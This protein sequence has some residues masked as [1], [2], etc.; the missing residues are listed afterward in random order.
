MSTYFSSSNALSPQLSSIKS[1]LSDVLL[2]KNSYES[3]ILFYVNVNGVYCPLNTYKINEGIYEFELSFDSPGGSDTSEVNKFI[4]WKDGSNKIIYGKVNNKY[5]ELFE[6]VEIGDTG[7]IYKYIRNMF[8]IDLNNYEINIPIICSSDLPSINHFHYI[9]ENELLDKDS[10]TYTI[11]KYKNFT[12]NS[13]NLNNSIDSFSLVNNYFPDKTKDNNISL[14]NGNNYKSDL[15]NISMTN[16]YRSKRDIDNFTKAFDYR[17]NSGDANILVPLTRSSEYIDSKEYINNC[18]QE[19][20]S[21]DNSDQFIY[22]YGMELPKNQNLS[23]EN[24]N[25]DKMYILCT[26]LYRYYDITLE[27]VPVNKFRIV[28][29]SDGTY[30]SIIIPLNSN[31]NYNDPIS[32][33]P[34]FMEDN[35]GNDITSDLSF[36]YLHT[37][38]GTP[39]KQIRIDIKSDER[40]NE[41]INNLSSYKVK[42][43]SDNKLN[44]RK[45][46]R[47]Y[48]FGQNFI[49]NEDKLPTIDNR[50][51]RVDP[52]EFTINYMYNNTEY[53]NIQS[54]I[55]TPYDGQVR[56]VN[57]LINDGSITLQR[58][59][60]SKNIWNDIEE[61]RY[62]YKT[63]TRVDLPNGSKIKVRYQTRSE[64]PNI[65]KEAITIQQLVN[66]SWINYESYTDVQ[67][68]NS[69]N[70]GEL[71]YFRHDNNL[72]DLKKLSWEIHDRFNK[73][74]YNSDSDNEI[75]F[76]EGSNRYIID[77]N[78][79]YITIQELVW[80]VIEECV[81]I[82][83]KVENPEL[84]SFMYVKDD[85]DN[86]TIYQWTGAEWEL[87]RYINIPKELDDSGFDLIRYR[88]G[89]VADTITLEQL[90]WTTVEGFE[91][92]H[93][94]SFNGF[95]LNSLRYVRINDDYSGPININILK[96]K[97]IVNNIDA[98][99]DMY[100]SF[101]PIIISK[102]LLD[103]PSESKNI[104]I[105]IYD[106]S[107]DNDITGDLS[108][109]SKWENGNLVLTKSVSTRFFDS[110]IYLKYYNETEDNNYSTFTYEITL[111]T[112]DIDDTM[113]TTKCIT[114]DRD[115]FKLNDYIDSNSRVR[116]D[117]DP[118]VHL[119]DRVGNCL[120]NDLR[121]YTRWNSDR[122]FEI[123]FP[124]M[125]YSKFIGLTLR[126]MNTLKLNTEE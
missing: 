120:D 90:S 58:Y 22:M 27:S 31:G 67:R 89:S 42:Y 60:S 74:I 16:I 76:V 48:S 69:P 100:L 112:D 87:S 70:E 51:L 57:S 82:P 49:D 40:Y 1:N 37:I 116:Y 105:F 122:N 73:V 32:D 41:L 55:I 59:D 53:S 54:T 46:L 96:W 118:V 14:F 43:Y 10:K 6:I 123:H 13:R 104:P 38:I 99:R 9:I 80:E 2:N 65:L 63:E 83:S 94:E 101:N 20:Y 4:T 29:S 111:H 17:S 92:I 12:S 15:C 24:F 86:V 97:D 95:S 102:S 19:V 84:N 71:R 114:I 108:I 23:T 124:A 30:H 72:I 35:N 56:Y 21:F 85:L 121:I 117:I 93:P 119:Y 50:V 110:G 125:N 79:D 26:S 91:D 28:E 77:T 88:E 18:T 47:L 5:V 78:T 107:N 81:D 34:F 3:L 45:Y 7:K 33:S 106:G 44:P 98:S 62:I 109:Q 36:S 66:D 8:Y 115:R 126:Y 11:D 113:R 75:K 39:N 103:L 52:L 61:L 64:D 68:I 25:L